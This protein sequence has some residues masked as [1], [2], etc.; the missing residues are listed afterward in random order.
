[1]ALAGG[2][3]AVWLTQPDQG[4][5]LVTPRT[6]PQPAATSEVPT[7][8]PTSR[9]T[10]ARAAWE[11]GAPRRLVIPA[12]EVDAPVVPVTAPDRTLIPPSDPQQL[13]WWS[14]GARPGATRG[15]ALVTGHTVNAGGGALDD[16]ETVQRG[17]RVVVQTAKMKLTYAVRT[18]RIYAKGALAQEA[19][20]VFSQEVPGRLVVITCEDWDGSQ[21]LSNVVV[22]AEPRR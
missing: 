22:V 12:L 21:Y 1:M 13:G 10:P 18:V 16:L 19:A 7:P 17:D 8:T 20:R 4:S 6:T 14:E 2:G 15:S 11:P 5:A 3:V 9:P